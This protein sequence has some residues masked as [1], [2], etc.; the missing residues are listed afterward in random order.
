[1]TVIA[2]GLIGCTVEQGLVEKREPPTATISA[3]APDAAFVQGSAPVALEGSVDDLPD[4]P[5]EL[6]ASWI[7]DGATIAEVTPTTDGFVTG[8]MSLEGLDPGPHEVVLRVVDTDGSLGEAK[9]A[10]TIDIPRSPPIAD[11]TAPVDASEFQPETPI[12]FTGTGADL[13]DA[14]E[15]LTFAWT[16][17]VDG[18]ITGATSGGGLSFVT[19]ALSEGE[20]VITL[21]VT[22][23]DGDV[24]T[25]SIHVKVGE[26]GPP[27]DPPE[28]AEPGDVIFS[29]L[30]INPQH[31]DDEVAEWV[32]LYNTGDT[33][34]DIGG[35]SF[36]DL[37]YDQF[38]LIGPIY[39]A[40]HDYVV[41]CANLDPKI[42]GGAECDAW[43]DRQI[44][45]GLALANKPDE[46][47][48][49]RPDGVEIDRLVY[50]QEWVDLTITG[51]AIGVDPAALSGTANDDFGNWCAMTT[52][53]SGG[54]WGTPGFVNDEC[55]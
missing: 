22:D 25:D 52:E 37:D 14:A 9:I 16:S 44:T 33:W 35:Y 2:L 18:A 54:D 21:T 43:F 4:R 24:G 32:E 11:I 53:L 36:H 20:H 55:F 45:G 30:M 46:V 49:T 51:Q 12:T 28:D 42:N 38:S 19:A 29:E 10:I 47:V 5:E 3:P 41:L 15:L 48:L 31:K 8:E 6:K 26:D 1:M 23:S 39:V 17:D 13:N 7:V 34:L 27:D 50:G 40:P